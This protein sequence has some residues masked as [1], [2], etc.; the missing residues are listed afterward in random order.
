LDGGYCYTV[1]GVGRGQPCST[2]LGGTSCAEKDGAG[3]PLS[4]EF[5]FTQS[6]SEGK[7]V[8]VGRAENGTACGGSSL[9]SCLALFPS[10]AGC[11]NGV[12][13][14]DD[15]KVCSQGVGCGPGLECVDFDGVQVCVDYQR[16]LGDTCQQGS[17][18]RGVWEQKCKP[19]YTCFTTSTEQFNVDG[20]CSTVV[21]PGQRC[22]PAENLQCVGP[23]TDGTCQ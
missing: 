9:D 1:V 15:R 7:D 3:K 5:Y 23:C 21:P 13:R 22:A 6:V 8:C 18:R 2:S 4:C 12:C 20:V 16:E 19:A 11:V 14:R 10:S 17:P